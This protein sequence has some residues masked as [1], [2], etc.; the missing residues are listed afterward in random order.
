[1]PVQLTDSISEQFMIDTGASRINLNQEKFESLVHQ[2]DPATKYA[3]R[4][5]TLDTK[6]LS[7]AMM[8]KFRLGPLTYDSI[9]IVEYPRSFLGMEFFRKHSLVTLDCLHRKLYLK[10]RPPGPPPSANP[11][12][13]QVPDAKLP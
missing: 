6:D 2:F 7:G 9:Q 1:L 11:A 8:N 12:K 5:I 4:P 13:P 10:Q 3:K